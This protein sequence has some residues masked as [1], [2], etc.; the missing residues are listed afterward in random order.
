METGR[1]LATHWRTWP[2][3][4]YSRLLRLTAESPMPKVALKFLLM[5]SALRRNNWRTDWVWLITISSTLVT[6]ALLALYLW[7]RGA[8]G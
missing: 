3:A 7:Q 5:M 4:S 8:I 6:I 1:C 2:I